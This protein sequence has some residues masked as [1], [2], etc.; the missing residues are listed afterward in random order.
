MRIFI[1]L[2]ALLT[3]NAYAH[4]QRVYSGGPLEIITI[5]HPTLTMVAQ[6]VSLEEIKTQEFQS[7]LDDM[8][9]TMRKAGGVGLA[10]PQVNISKRIFVIKPSLFKKAQFII[11]PVID[12]NEELGKKASKEGCLSIPGKSFTVDRYKEINVTYYDRKANYKAE[13][14]TG[15]RAIVMQHE[16]DHLN[17]IMIS[18][19][20]NL[21]ELGLESYIDVPLM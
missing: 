11:N 7:F 3:A 6:E 18:D 17:G 5:G 21:E 15:F 12:Y 2:T 8:L 16:F 20:F 4:T 9:K 13:K 1:L 19:F 10:A 14:A